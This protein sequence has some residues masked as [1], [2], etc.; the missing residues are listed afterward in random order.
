M[1]PGLPQQALAGII[2]VIAVIATLIGGIILALGESSRSQAA[3]ATATT[4]RIPTLPP[5]SDEED[6]PTQEA[7]SS[8]D[9][10]VVSIP[11]STL[12][13]DRDTP[14]P[15]RRT[16]TPTPSDS[17]CDIPAGWV[18]YTV[19]PED[20]IYS[21]A[22]R[23]GETGDSIL[24]ANCLGNQT[25]SAGDVIYV[26]PVTPRAISDF[27]PSPVPTDTGE[28]TATPSP[29][30][31]GTQTA[32]DGACTNLDSVITSPTVGTI[33]TGTVEFVGSAKVPD[34]A[35][36]KLEIRQEGVTTAGDYMTFF[37]GEQQ[38]INGLLAEFNT[39]AFPNGEYWI[40]LVVVNDTGNYPERCAILYTIQ[41]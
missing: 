10:T 26:P 12:D 30:P 15:T 13:P 31:T 18:T 33:L 40:R 3:R 21:I 27:I 23:Y 17:V 25:V 1:R 34:F 8:P 5:T 6:S 29:G 38:V 37:T 28:P 11:T 2:V 22:I 4:Y 39:L 7:T 24:E 9:V 41:N 32:T 20:N 14:T 36:Y 19:Q 16:R 35:Y